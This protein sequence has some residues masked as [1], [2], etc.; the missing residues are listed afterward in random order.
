MEEKKKSWF[1]R[2]WILS[3]FL[4]LIVLGMIGSLFGGD[5]ESDLTGDVVN[6]QSVVTDVS[7]ILLNNENIKDITIKEGPADISWKFRDI[8]WSWNSQ[9]GLKN[10]IYQEAT[11]IDI[12]A[13]KPISKRIHFIIDEAYSK[14][15]AE[16]LYNLGKD[17][18]PCQCSGC[19]PETQTN[20]LNVTK[21]FVKDVGDGS[22]IKTYY[23]KQNNSI[24]DQRYGGFIDKTIHIFFTKDNLLMVVSYTSN[25]ESEDYISTGIT[26]AERMIDK[27]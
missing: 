14:S 1:R 2:H 6:E 19:S 7:D 5:S 11:L 12:R 9:S 21:I 25:D 24:Y 22:T 20:C 16:E 13:L 17:M 8:D 10:S 18:A 15:I 3:I 26:I 4:G 23:D 27:I